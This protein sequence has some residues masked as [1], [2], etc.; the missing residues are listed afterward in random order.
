MI[1]MNELNEIFGV[2]DVLVGFS[3]V[4]SGASTPYVRPNVLG[5]GTNVFEL[6]QCRHPIV[7]KTLTT[8]SFI[9]NDIVFGKRSLLYIIILLM[10]NLENGK[11]FMVLTGANMGGK[12]TYLRSA[13]ITVLFAQI[14]CFVPC[15]SAV[16]SIVDSILTRVGA[17]DCQFK[18]VSTFMAEMTDSATILEKATENSLIIVDELGRG[19]TTFDGFG[20]AWAIAE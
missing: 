14:G 17:G 2:L 18:G 16:F 9:P 4:S 3:I 20:L 13:A 5:M 15:E 10:I 6:K 1:A 19:T 7:E 12:S 11:K 8:S